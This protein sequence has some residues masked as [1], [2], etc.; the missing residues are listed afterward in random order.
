MEQFKRA[1][2]VMIP[3]NQK[4]KNGIWLRSAKFGTDQH[5]FNNIYS[6]VCGPA[7]MNECYQHLYITSDDKINA[8]D[9][10]IDDTNTIRK[11]ITSDPDYWEV[12]PEYKKII[13]TT[14]T[15]LFTG[16]KFNLPQPSS[17]FIKKYVDSYNKGEIITDVMVEYA[18]FDKELYVRINR[19]DNTITIKKVKDSWTKEEVHNLMMQAWI[20]GEAKPNQHYSVREN[21]I[22]ENL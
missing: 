13:A 14:D 4:L 20:N 16:V 21:W 12:R 5:L 6:A 3:T 19:K 22:E 8:E 11:A 18:L 7:L 10:Y 2:V 1:K 17:Q 9:W 15:S